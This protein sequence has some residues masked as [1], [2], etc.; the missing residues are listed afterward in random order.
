MQRATQHRGASACRTTRGGGGVG[1]G[2]VAAACAFGLALTTA[3]CATVGGLVAP[4][5]SDAIVRPTAPADYD[6][7]VARELEEEGDLPASAAAYTRAVVKDPGSAFLRLELAQVEARQGHYSQAVEQG[8]QA[9]VLA[10][11]DADTRRFLGTLYRVGKRVD[12]AERVLRGAD[13]QPIDEDAALLLYSLYLEGERL[14]EALAVGEW[15]VAHD[16]N[17]LRGHFAVAAAYEKM[18]RFEDSERALRDALVQQPGSLAVY[19]AMARSRRDRGDRDGEIAVYREA[20]VAHPSHPGTLAAMAE[21]LIAAGRTD[22]AIRTLEELERR[23]PRDARATLRLG[24]LE[25]EAKRYEAA[26]ARF[27][28]VLAKSPEQHDVAY[29]LGL[30]RRRMN[31]DVRAAEA[32]E[33]VPPDHERWVEARA[34]L[35]AIQEKRGDYAGALAEIEAARRQKPDRDLDIYAASLR[36]KTGDTRGAVA[37]LEQLLE[38]SPEDDE[39]MYQIGVVLGDAKRYD[40]SLVWMQRALSQNPDNANAL[41]YLGYTWADQGRNLD[42]AE[43]MIVHAL[44]LKPNDG[45]ITDSLGWVYFMRARALQQGGRHD[46]GRA[47]LARAI[48]K[49]ELADELSGGDPVISEHLGDAYRLQGDASRALHHYRQALDQEPRRGEQPELRRKYDELRQE[50]GGT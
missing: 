26:A 31:D 19:G 28:S 4:R 33:R 41:N 2:A 7:L 29:F 20:L 22:E 11:D 16:P 21:A 17:A 27:E 50:L 46:E 5:R 12:D 42:Q 8:E 39:L 45:F 36:A 24:F 34:Q 32:F 23:Q 48:E 47:E 43:Q 38:A 1:A 49:L 40:E 30:V 37:A 25:Y 44:E 10:P 6:F 15:V 14:P 35:A 3:G 9:L 13:G 18:G